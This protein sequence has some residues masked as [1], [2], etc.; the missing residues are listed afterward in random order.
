MAARQC[1]RRLPRGGSSDIDTL[2]YLRFLGSDDFI[3]SFRR[4]WMVRDALIKEVADSSARWTEHST[5]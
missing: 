3:F 4:H 5:A 1:L 2:V